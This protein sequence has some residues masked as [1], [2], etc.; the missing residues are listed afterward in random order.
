[1]ALKGEVRGW[2]GIEES[3]GFTFTSLSNTVGVESLGTPK[4]EV[5]GSVYDPEN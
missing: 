3:Q 4:K 2:Y 5:W 1:M